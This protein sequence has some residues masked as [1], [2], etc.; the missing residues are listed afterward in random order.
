M[1]LGWGWGWEVSWFGSPCRKDKYEKHV[2]EFWVDVE[3]VGRLD[4]LHSEELNQSYVIVDDHDCELPSPMLGKSSSACLELDGDDTD[5]DENEDDDEDEEK[6]EPT[7]KSKSKKKRA[8]TTPS[9]KSRR[10]A[11]LKNS[12]T[13]TTR[14]ARKAAKAQ[15]EEIEQALEA[16]YVVFHKTLN[17]HDVLAECYPKTCQEMDRIPTILTEILK[18]RIKMDNTMDSLKKTSG[19][20]AKKLLGLI[21]ELFHASCG[22]HGYKLVFSGA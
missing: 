7:P 9:P 15:E 14:S 10:R 8:K 21:I 4:T 13:K 2:R 20:D 1:A 12:S 16:T 17:F 22:L 11:I 6:E 5:E 18:L 19:E 3:T